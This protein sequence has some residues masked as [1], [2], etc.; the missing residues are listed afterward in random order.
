[1]GEVG[2]VWSTVVSAGAGMATGVEPL[3]ETALAERK[4]SIPLTAW[5]G[6][7]G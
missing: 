6:K 5:V 2:V 1:M 7:A 4:W 3:L